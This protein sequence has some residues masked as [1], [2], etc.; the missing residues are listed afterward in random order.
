MKRERV[1]V[2]V[3][4]DIPAGSDV[5]KFIKIAGGNSVTKRSVK[6]N[7][8]EPLS[9]ELLNYEHRRAEIKAVRKILNDLLE[10][11]D[12]HKKVCVEVC[13]RWNDYTKL[14]DNVTGIN[15]TFRNRWNAWGGTTLYLCADLESR[16]YHSKEHNDYGSV[17]GK[18]VA[19]LADPDLKDLAKL[20]TDRFKPKSKQ[21]DDNFSK[22]L[23]QLSPKEKKALGD[24]FGPFTC[25]AKMGLMGKCNSPICVSCT[26]TP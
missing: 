2:E 8:T 20:V 3:V 7:N 19:T 24:I 5:N 10:K 12:L 16:I 14:R 13:N 15:I 1:T 11:L 18:S 4:L 21:Q 23:G 26:K 22:I 17:H 25:G 6:I 9:D